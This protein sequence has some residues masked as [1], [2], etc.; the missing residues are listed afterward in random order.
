MQMLRPD[1]TYGDICSDRIAARTPR[2]APACIKLMRDYVL[3]HNRNTAPAGWK[4][5][6]MHLPQIQMPDWAQ[7]REVI[8]H[9]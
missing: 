9:V 4:L 7:T 3:F 1:G 6:H 2:A 5:Q 8:L